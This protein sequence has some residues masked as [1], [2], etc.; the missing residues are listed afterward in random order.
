[1]AAIVLEVE[2]YSIVSW[3]RPVQND[4]QLGVATASN[5]K[6]EAR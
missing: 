6:F 5:W 4:K 3:A 2:F 1:M